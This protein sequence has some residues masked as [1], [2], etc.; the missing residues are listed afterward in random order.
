[1]VVSCRKTDDSERRRG[2]D[3]VADAVR[4]T[5]ANLPN[6]TQS[7]I[8]EYLPT[9]H[10]ILGRFTCLIRKSPWQRLCSDVCRPRLA[11]RWLLRCV[12]Q[13]TYTTSSVCGKKTRY[14]DTLAQDMLVSNHS[15]ARAWETSYSLSKLCRLARQSLRTDTV[16]RPLQFRTVRFRSAP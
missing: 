13:S 8:I 2:A 4:K 9:R 1:M 15:Y 6:G 12:P 3:D 10:A 14:K 5:R 11:R 16:Q 7:R